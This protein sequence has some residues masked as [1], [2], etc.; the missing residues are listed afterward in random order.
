MFV[1]YYHTHTGLDSASGFS[2][3]TSRVA[4]G[5]VGLALTLLTYIWEV[6]GSKLL[7]GLPAIPMSFPSFNDLLHLKLT[8]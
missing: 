5:G 4:T 7:T 1:V 3:W 2:R 8:L 6:I